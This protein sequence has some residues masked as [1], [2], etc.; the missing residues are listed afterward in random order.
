MQN[1]RE[2]TA[3]ILME[4]IN[5]PASEAVVIDTTSY[6]RLQINNEIG[7]FGVFVK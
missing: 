6:Q 4:R 7:I 2:R 3:F 1:S 5:P